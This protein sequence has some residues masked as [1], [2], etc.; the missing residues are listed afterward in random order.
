M[1]KMVLAVTYLT[2]LSTIVK[3]LHC[4]IIIN[5]VIKQYVFIFAFVYK[6][7]PFIPLQV[8]P[9]IHYILGAEGDSRT[10]LPKGEYNKAN[11]NTVYG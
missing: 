5:C 6:K 10:L 11:L 2:I 3:A 4:N 8:I 9:S 1:I 7:V